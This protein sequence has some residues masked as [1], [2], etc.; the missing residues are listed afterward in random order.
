MTDVPG[1]RKSKSQ[2]KREMIALQKLGER[3]VSLTAEQIG[4]I[5]MPG[6][7]RDAVLFVQT[8]KGHGARHRQM[9]YIGALMRKTDPAPIQKILDDIDGGHKTAARLFHQIEQRRDELVDGGDTL[10]DDM[11][12]QFP[13]CDRH[14]LRR[15]VCNAKKEKETARDKSKAS[16]ALFRYLKE[17]FE[18]PR[19][20]HEPS[21][22]EET[23][24]NEVT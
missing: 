12:G 24:G 19:M 6:E 3:L 4:K 21:G 16:R 18:N 20:A 11:C 9:Q 7:L 8:I 15:L 1:D 22:E 2:I 10:V 14:R 23:P 13:A 17:L 5:N